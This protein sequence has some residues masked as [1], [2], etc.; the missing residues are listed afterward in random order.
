MVTAV[1]IVLGG[2]EDLA[3]LGRD[4]GVAVDES[5][6][7]AAQ[8]LDAERKRRHVEQQH[9]LDVALQD[10]GLDGGADGDDLVGIDALVR[11]LAEEALH[12][13]LHLGH[14]RHAA[15]Q[16]HF[17][18]LLGSM[19]ASFN[20]ALHGPDRALDRGRRPALSSLARV[21][22]MSRCLGPFWSAVMKG[23]LMLG[24]HGRG[25]L[26]FRLL[27]GLL[28]TLQRQA[29]VA[30][31]DALLFLELVG[32]VIDDPFVEILAAQECVAIGRFD[33]EDAVA[34][35][36]DRDVEGAAAEIVDGDLAGLFLV[37]AV[38][39]RRR[40][41]LVDD[42]QDLEA[43]D[44]AGVL[45]R[46]ALG[47]VEI[48]RN[49]DDGLRDLFAEIT[50]GGLLHLLQDEGGDLRGR[51]FLAVGLDPGVAIV[52]AHDLV[53]H[54]ALVLLDD[55]DRRSGGRSGA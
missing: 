27:G 22:L 2:R 38:G 28:Q 40:R 19:P 29:V 47:I 44:L 14:A 26:D 23:R 1:L 24:F 18:D 46:L 17:V 39:E 16:H 7:H 34:D 49:G 45:G 10:A 31:V 42:A 32:E 15:D 35:F 25:E 21:S 4:R 50:L 51:V 9:V 41:R 53:G 13:L 54:E 8:R 3:L 36:E 5:R 33:L 52:A 48:G 43:G 6:E 37:E 12:D 55:R 20:A 30:Q 11:L